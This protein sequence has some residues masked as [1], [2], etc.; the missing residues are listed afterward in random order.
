MTLSQ[1]KAIFIWGTIISTVIFLGL[2]YDSIS[3]MP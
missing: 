2:T 1:G 3:K